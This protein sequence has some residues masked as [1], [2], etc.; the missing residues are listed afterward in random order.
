M[1]GH[2]YESSTISICTATSTNQVQFQYVWPLLRNTYI[3]E[4]YGHFYESRTLSINIAAS[5]NHAQFQAYMY[6]YD[7]NNNDN[8]NLFFYVLL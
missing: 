7:N 6:L 8:K 1:Y 3:F 4:M 2:F 5:K